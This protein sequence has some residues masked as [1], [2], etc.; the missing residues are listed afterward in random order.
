MLGRRIN[1][2]VGFENDEGERVE[3]GEEVGACLI[4]C[5]QAILR[6]CLVSRMGE[7]AKEP[8][9]RW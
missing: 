9:S 5:I 4:L 6:S 8:M 1:E 7:V 2:I 3:R